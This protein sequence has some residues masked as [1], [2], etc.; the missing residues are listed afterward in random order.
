MGCS[1]AEAADSEVSCNCCRTSEQLS[2]GLGGSGVFNTNVGV[3]VCQPKRF[4]KPNKLIVARDAA[5]IPMMS[6]HLTVNL[7]TA[8]GTLGPDLSDGTGHLGTK[9]KTP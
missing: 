2:G 7:D 6:M 9:S 5:Q 1:R 8:C 3:S 4:R